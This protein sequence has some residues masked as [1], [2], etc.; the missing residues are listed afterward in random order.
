M[1]LGGSETSLILK[2]C[3]YLNQQN[4]SMFHNLN[5]KIMNVKQFWHN[6]KHVSLF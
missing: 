1:L 6:T 5:K 3:M 2:N 4:V